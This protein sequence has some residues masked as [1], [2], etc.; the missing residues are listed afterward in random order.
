MNRLLEELEVVN[1]VTPADIS[2]ADVTG[3]YVG[4]SGATRV[5]FVLTTGTISATKNATMKL[6]QAKDDTGMDSK[7]LIGTVTAVAPTGGSTLKVEIE[8]MGDDLDTNNGYAFVA[9][10]V[11]SDDTSKI[12]CV[13]AIRGGLRYSK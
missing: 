5:A 9:P 8:V 13:I 3:S 4:L 12:G 7:D 11:G 6:I 10:V 1:C 2:T